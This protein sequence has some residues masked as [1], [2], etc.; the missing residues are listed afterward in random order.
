MKLEVISRPQLDANAINRFL[1]AE[2]M[3]WR[4]TAGATP[5]EELVELAGRICYMSFGKRQSPKTNAEYIANLVEMGHESVLEHVCWTFVLVGVSRAFTHQ[6]VRHRVG[7]AF[8]QLSQQY[9]DETDA[10]FIEPAYL[11]QYPTARAAWLDAMQ[12]SKASYRKILDSLAEM[13]NKH[14]AQI[15]K[16]EIRRAIKSVAR[17][18]LPNATE[19]KIV[20]TANARALRYFLRVRGTIPGDLE[21]REIAAAM[22]TAVSA[23]APALFADFSIDHWPDGP[24]IIFRGKNQAESNSLG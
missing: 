18:V 22:L 20:V 4:H 24:V 12:V 2:G 10:E 3:N 23:D 19:S 14:K 13:E 16:R 21:M 9:H 11:S 1:E 6:L 7:F 17:S 15:D 8:S 5:A